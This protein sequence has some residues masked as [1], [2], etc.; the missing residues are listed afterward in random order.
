MS[1]GGSNVTQAESWSDIPERYRDFVDENLSLAG[2][3]GNRA[4]TPYQGQRVAGFT[5]DQNAAFNTVRQLPNQY[6]GMV[7]NANQALTN[8][9]TPV[10]AQGYNPAT[11]QASQAQ[12]ALMPSAQGYDAA[13]IAGTSYNPVLA[14]FGAAGSQGYDASNAAASLANRGDIRDVNAA[15]GASQMSQ[16]ANPYE[17]EVTQRVIDDMARAFQIANNQIGASAAGAGAYGGSRH[18]VAE[19]EN[20]RNFYDRAGNV[21][22]N[23]R[24]AGFNTAAG[25]GQAD[26]SRQLQAGAQNQSADQAT[27]ALN[28]QLGTSV[29]LNNAAVQNAAS[30]FGAQASNTAA[31]QNATQANNMALANVG[32]Q[33]EAGRY[34]A[35]SGV[36]AQLANAAAQNAARQ[37]GAGSQNAA[38]SQ[39]SQ[40][41]TQ[42]ALANAGSQNAALEASANAMN[43][44]G[45]FNAQQANAIGQQNVANQLAAGQAF[46]GLAGQTQTLGMNSAN[47]LAGIGQQQQGLNQAQMDLNYGDFLQEYNYPYQAL[48]LRQSA[49]GQTPMGQVGMQPVVSQSGGAGGLLGGLGSLLQGGAALAPFLGTCWVAR[50]VYGEDDPQW[51]R[52]REWMLSKAPESL[53]RF[54]IENGERIAA[55]ISDKPDLKSEIRGMMDE[56]VPGVAS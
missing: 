26:A 52:F 50:E 31:L 17:N 21:A 22:A 29:G 33:N 41:A 35:D 25:L 56:L 45:Q 42:A 20:A 47:A 7:A 48:A 11:F 5:D 27:T 49:I 16:Y 40:L 54:Y 13:T 15:T 18:A 6:G 37:F 4:Y 51:L 2:T 39:N 44:S 10:Q 9:A 55:Y 1:K 30:Q 28:A 14:N 12:A 3:L 19:T 8:A 24:Q 32:F 36:Q 46:G 23:I 34:A 38:A 53:R 43:Q